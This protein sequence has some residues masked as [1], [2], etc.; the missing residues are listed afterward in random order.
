MM[1]APTE[2]TYENGI[3]IFSLNFFFFPTNVDV[4]KD[5]GSD[6]EGWAFLYN[7]DSF[8]FFFFDVVVL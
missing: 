1:E 7:M 3:F 8:I 6:I 4:Q 5:R 2:S